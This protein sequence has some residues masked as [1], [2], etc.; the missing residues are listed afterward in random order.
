[1]H[2]RMAEEAG[3][4]RRPEIMEQE[5]LENYLPCSVEKILVTPH[6]SFGYRLDSSS[7]PEVPT[8]PLSPNSSC[9]VPTTHDRGTCTVPG[10]GTPELSSASHVCHCQSSGIPRI[11]CPCLPFSSSARPPALTSG[12]SHTPAASQTVRS[13]ET[14][15]YQFLL[16]SWTFQSHG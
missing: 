7:L 14:V 3:G 5:I 12:Y 15:R 16:H 6:S 8:A 13:Q 10:T 9:P 4:G 2:L 1:M 11:F